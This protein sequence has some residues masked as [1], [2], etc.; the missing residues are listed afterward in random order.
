MKVLKERGETH[1]DWL[2]VSHTAQ[3]IKNIIAM[4]DNYNSMSP[5]Q[6]EALDMIA[7][8]IARIV[9]GDP[10]VKD[11]WHD[12]AGYATLAEQEI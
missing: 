5:A 9:N 6:R 11:H 3:D 1:G 10:N 8:K 4:G 2:S 7:T 12:I